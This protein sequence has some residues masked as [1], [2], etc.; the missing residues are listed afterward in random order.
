M[1]LGTMLDMVFRSHGGGV[2]GCREVWSVEKD[3]RVIGE[4]KV[5][6]R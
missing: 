1:A 4:C 2:D 3:N 5:L 6:C